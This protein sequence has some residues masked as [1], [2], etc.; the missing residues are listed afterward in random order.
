MGLIVLRVACE[1]LEMNIDSSQKGLFLMRHGCFVGSGS[2]D[3]L[4]IEVFRMKE[5]GFEFIGDRC[6]DKRE[7]FSYSGDNGFKCFSSVS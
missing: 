3:E 1:D 4:L 2:V 5:H 7:V 6:N